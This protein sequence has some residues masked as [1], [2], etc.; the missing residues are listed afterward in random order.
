[1]K[2]ILFIIASL[3]LSSCAS[4]NLS[5]RRPADQVEKIET[6]PGSPMTLWEKHFLRIDRR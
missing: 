6:S 5:V 1:M 3:L 4:K 2:G